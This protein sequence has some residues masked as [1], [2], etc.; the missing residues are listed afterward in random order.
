MAIRYEAAILAVAE[1]ARADALAVNAGIPS[2]SLMEAA[3]EAVARA[4]QRRWARGPAT[5]LC[6]PGNNGGD[7]LVA[8]RL[9]REAGWPVRLGPF[10]GRPGLAGGAAAAAAR[11]ARRARALDR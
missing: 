2:M 10:G 1:M 11:L 7:G 4:A 8:A 9:L 6:G 5:V 3:G